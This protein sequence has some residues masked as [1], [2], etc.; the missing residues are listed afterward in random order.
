VKVHKSFKIFSH[1]L[2]FRFEQKNELLTV[3]AN[4]CIDIIC[5]A[6][7]LPENYGE[8]IVPVE[9]QL[10]GFDCFHNLN[11]EQSRRGRTSYGA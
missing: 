1:E 3:I 7:T 4:E 9:F 5:I 8:K 2:G 10:S 6:E 11:E